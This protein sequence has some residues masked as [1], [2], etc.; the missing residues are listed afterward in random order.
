M[1]GS[2]QSTSDIQCYKCGSSIHES[3]TEVTTAWG[4]YELTLKGVNALKCENCG[5]AIFRAQDVRMMQN[6][7]KSPANHKPEIEYLNATET[8]SILRVSKQSVYNMIKDGR[9]KAHK[10]GREWRFMPGDIYAV[11]QSSNTK[12][13]IRW[14]RRVEK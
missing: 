4:E 14:P 7:S 5:E 6:L 11:G 1:L 2:P 9:V 12:H 13:Q 8:T 3:K 10:I